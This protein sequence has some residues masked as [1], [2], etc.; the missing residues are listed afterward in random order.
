MTGTCAGPCGQYQVKNAT[1]FNGQGRSFKEGTAL[2]EVLTKLCTD[3]SIDRKLQGT[4][5]RW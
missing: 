3:V 5:G 2:G 4:G 1:L